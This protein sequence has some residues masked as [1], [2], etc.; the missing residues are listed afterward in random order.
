MNEREKLEEVKK[1]AEEVYRNIDS[2]LCPY[3]KTK[4]NF[5]AK[6]LDH[7]KMKSWNKAR[8]ASDQY[9][10]LKFLRL[11]PEVLK[12][13]GTLQEIKETKNFERIKS[14]GKWQSLMKPVVYYGFIAIIRK[15]KIKVIVKKIENGQPYFWSIIPYWK[16]QKDELCQKIKK[17]F[18][19]GDLEND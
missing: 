16:S 17:V 1:E 13:S 18:H 10:R 2:V 3:L 8:L 4:V 6:G 5:N 12:G 7:I 19:E 15:V 14:V 11:A 9:L